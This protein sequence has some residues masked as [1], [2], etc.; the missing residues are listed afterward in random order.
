MSS[1]RE[2]FDEP[3]IY[4]AMVFVAL[5]SYLEILD[6]PDSTETA[7]SMIKDSA[8]FIEECRL[9]RLG[10]LEELMYVSEEIFRRIMEV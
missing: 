8:E 5:V 1:D 4:T 7:Q 3:K 9:K 2:K 6:I 10:S